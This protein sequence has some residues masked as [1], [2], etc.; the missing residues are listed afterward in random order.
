MTARAELVVDPIACTGYGLCMEIAPELI[1]PDDWG[2]PIVDR[3]EVPPDLL[4]S[5]HAAVRLCPQL[6]LRL[7]T[8]TG[9]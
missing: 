1:A 8:P 4:A 6:A 9:R 7:R 5:A 3:G 2:F